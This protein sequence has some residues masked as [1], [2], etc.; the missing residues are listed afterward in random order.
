MIHYT[1]R[2]AL[3]WNYCSR[4]TVQV[5]LGWHSGNS[6]FQLRKSWIDSAES[7]HHCLTVSFWEGY[8]V[9]VQVSYRNGDA[10][11]SFWQPLFLSFF[12]IMPV[13]S[14][15]YIP[16]PSNTSER[17]VG[18]SECIMGR[19]RRGFIM[20]AQQKR[21]KSLSQTFR[22]LCV[23]FF[24]LR[25]QPCLCN[26][27]LP[28]HSSKYFLHFHKQFDFVQLT[29]RSSSV[30]AAL[31][32]VGGVV[33]VGRNFLSST[34]LYLNFLFS[35]R[36][37]HQDSSKFNFVMICFEKTIIINTQVRLHCV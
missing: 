33:I 20:C 3:V 7:W 22:I 2:M 17:K 1:L 9:S 10:D 32:H 24:F 34:S 35:K 6:L 8:L 11:T 26:S 36:G 31:F 18:F 12:P 29:D 28:L 25:Q 27:L 30:P 5:P 15:F 13:F 23:K 19:C 21:R 37:L 4:R 14:T 16:L